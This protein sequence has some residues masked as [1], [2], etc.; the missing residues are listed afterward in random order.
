MQLTF[1]LEEP[2]KKWYRKGEIEEERAKRYLEE[3]ERERREKEERK[4]KRE[5]EE[6]QHVCF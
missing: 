6:R 3:M 5:E 4:R 2:N 1:D